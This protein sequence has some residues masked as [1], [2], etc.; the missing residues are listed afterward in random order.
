MRAPIR[1]GRSFRA[2]R[3]DLNIDRDRLTNAGNRFSRWSKHQVEVT[4]RDRIGGHRPARPSGFVNW[5]EQFHVKCH[6]LRHAMH[7]QVAKNV[8]ILRAG[9]LYAA[10]F[11]RDMGK[12]LDIEKFRASQMVVAFFNPC[13][14]AAYVDL[15]RD[16][17]VLRM[18][19]INFD[20]PVEARELTLSRAEE[21]VHAETDCG[22]G[23]V[24]LVGVLGRGRTTESGYPE[25]G[26]KIE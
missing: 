8:A 7:C 11:E 24:E 20:L 16:G 25:H 10:A 12:F 21:L 4:P 1:D 23:W 26:N 22:S 6:R 3:F 13:I 14:D 9:A 5:R 17:R 2:L 18:F 19:P 15:R